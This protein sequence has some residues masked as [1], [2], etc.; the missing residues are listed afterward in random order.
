M[1]QMTT[2]NCGKL[3]MALRNLH[4]CR[5]TFV[6]ELLNKIYTGLEFGGLIPERICF[7]FPGISSTEK[8]YFSKEKEFFLYGEVIL[9][10]EDVCISKEHCVFSRRSDT[11]Y[12][13][14]TCYCGK[15]V[16]RA[17]LFSNQFFIVKVKSMWAV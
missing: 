8:M 4:W 17:Q 12:G 3:E 14:A 16:A 10:T 13:Q 1:S 6:H 5:T 7:K 11:F 9:F 15:W 2:L